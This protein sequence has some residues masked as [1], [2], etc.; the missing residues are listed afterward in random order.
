M[1]P[2]EEHALGTVGMKQIVQQRAVLQKL[3][4]DSGRSKKRL[5]NLRAK[6]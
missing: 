5:T 4:K 3:M 2:S 1:M 6:H